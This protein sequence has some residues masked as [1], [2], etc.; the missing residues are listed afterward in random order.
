MSNEAK[1]KLVAF[2]AEVHMS[3]YTLEW[4]G[5][6]L[7]E[8]TPLYAQ[9]PAQEQQSAISPK[10]CVWARNGHQVCP[11]AAPAQE[12]PNLAC[13]S[14]QKRLATQ[15]G[16][17]PAQEQPA[18]YFNR[19]AVERAISSAEN[20]APGTMQLNDGKERVT[21]P[22]GTLR[23]MLAIIDQ[24]ATHPTP[25]ERA[26]QPKKL[27]FEEWAQ[28]NEKFLDSRQCINE[29]GEVYDLMRMAFKAAQENK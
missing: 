8:G 17:V 24:L 5:A 1:T 2:V 4:N 20:P 23:R 6:P 13:K 28:K 7:P 15:W 18:P 9:P 14:V 29:Y 16:Y 26:E 22:G 12:H 25:A 19:A 10:D 21:L 3:R 11:S 27:T